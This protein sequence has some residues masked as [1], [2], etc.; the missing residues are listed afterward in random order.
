MNQEG[1]K[2]K[3]AVIFRNDENTTIRTSAIYRETIT[4]LIQQYRK[5]GKNLNQNGTNR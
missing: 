4:R 2:R 3:L 1:F 5:R